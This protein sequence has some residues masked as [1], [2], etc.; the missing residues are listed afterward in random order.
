MKKGDSLW[1]E[2]ESENGSEKESEKESLEAEDENHHDET[3]ALKVSDD[4]QRLSIDT[5][6]GKVCTSDK[7]ALTVFSDD[8]YS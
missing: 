7:I 4:S 8:D 1:S 5:D 6:E 2:K 3:D